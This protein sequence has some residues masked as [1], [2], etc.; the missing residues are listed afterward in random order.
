MNKLHVYIYMH[1]YLSLSVKWRLFLFQFSLFHFPTNIKCVNSHLS[2]ISEYLSCR[3]SGV[4]GCQVN[5]VEL[6]QIVLLATLF[7]W[8]LHFPEF[9]LWFQNRIDTSSIYMRFGR[10]KQSRTYMFWNLLVICWL[11]VLRFKWKV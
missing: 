10:Y 9:S 6:S 1:A 11:D 4:S 2:I 8:E 7:Y 5:E 3:M